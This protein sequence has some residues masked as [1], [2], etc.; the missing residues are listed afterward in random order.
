[1][2]DHEHFTNKIVRIF[3]DS[4]LS[5]ILI[6]LATI[7]GFAAL[8]LTPREEDPQIVVPLADIYVNFPGH[9]AAEVE[10][11]IATPLERVLYQIDGVEFV[12]SMSREGQAIITVRFYVGEDRERSLVKLY[13]KIDEHLDVVPSGV[14]GWIVKP[15]EI[16]DVPIATLTLASQSADDMKIRRVAEELAQRLAGIQEVSRAYVVGGRP[17][18]V[19]VLMDTDRMSAYHVS[20]LELRWAIQAT[21]VRQMAGD[22]RTGD[23]LIRVDAGEPFQDARQLRELVVGVFNGRPVFLK[24]VAGVE[25]GADEVTS[26]VRHGFGPARGFTKDLYFPSSILGEFELGTGDSTECGGAQPAVT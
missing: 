23:R 24:D 11:L 14:T 2:P 3:L 4:K 10:Q 20:P 21:N 17:R 5:L 16:D 26:Y 12:Y 8:W 9:S 6:L 7:L 13:K 25:D 1:M 22:V 19:Q 15:V 18:V